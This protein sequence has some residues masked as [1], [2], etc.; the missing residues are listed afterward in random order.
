MSLDYEYFPSF[1]AAV[2]A[3]GEGYEDGVHLCGAA[4]VTYDLRG[5]TRQGQPI[6]GL[7]GYVAHSLVAIAIASSRKPFWRPMRI[8]DVGG[9]VGSAYAWAYSAFR[10]E[11]ECTI[12]ETQLCAEYGKRFI[13][14]PG[15]RFVH[16]PS[17]LRGRPDLVHMAGVLPYVPD[18]SAMLSAAVVRAAPFVFISRTMLG[19]EEEYFVQRVKRST[20]ATAQPGRILSRRAIDDRMAALGYRLF[21]SWD[22]TSWA[23]GARSLPAPSLLW[24]RA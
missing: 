7:P 22:D 24:R 10:M 19:D 5:R 23:G 11:S 9:G 18:V 15:L 20:G 8:L 16:D 12:L 6:T 1:E 4:E 14:S 13:R 21:A 2:A 3:A 17:A